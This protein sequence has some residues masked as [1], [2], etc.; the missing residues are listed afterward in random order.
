M[1]NK[2]VLNSVQ[3]P[4]FFLLVQLVIAVVLL[5]ISVI[6][7]KSCCS[8]SRAQVD[9][10]RHSL[11]LIT[12]PHRLLHHPSTPTIDMYRPCTPYWYQRDGSH[13]QHL[14]PTIRRRFILPS[15]SGPS[16]SIYSPI[17]VP[18]TLYALFIWHS[19]ISCDRMPGLLP[20]RIKSAHRCF[21]SWD[22]AGSFLKSH[23]KRTRD[24]CQE[25][26]K[27]GQRKHDG[28]SILQ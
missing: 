9:L 4:L 15:S 19:S 22:D 21:T 10:I 12:S 16:P 13:L 17:L 28:L 23:Y 2:W 8:E 7:G 14:L 6:F 27:C 25:E 11:C 26:S 1:A 18:P 24:S 3:V 20:R 5:H